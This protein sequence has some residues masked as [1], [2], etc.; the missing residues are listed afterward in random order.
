MFRN[1]PI[2]LS[3]YGSAILIAEM[4]F[5]DEGID[6]SYVPVYHKTIFHHNK[7]GSVSIERNPKYPYKTREEE[8]QARSRHEKIKREYIINFLRENYPDTDFAD[9]YAKDNK[10]NIPLR[11]HT[12]ETQK[13]NF[14]NEDGRH[15]NKIRPKT[16]CYTC[17]FVCGLPCG[18]C[19]KGECEY[20]EV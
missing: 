13:C 9:K 5:V 19:E 8:R 12:E 17:C 10:W 14:L 6:K 1:E 15:C 4:S 18:E 11:S 7:D 3:K 16:T 20:I 2:V